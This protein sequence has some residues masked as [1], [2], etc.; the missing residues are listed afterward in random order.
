[1]KVVYVIDSLASK[2]GAE[3]ILSDKMNYLVAQ[4]EFEVYVITCYQ[5]PLQ[6]HN[7]YELSAKVHQMDLSIPY[8]SQYKYRY[9]KRLWIKWRIYCRLIRELTATIQSL[10]P[11]ILVGVSY[12]HA[13]V[14]SCIPCRAF[15]VIESHEVRTFTMSDNGLNRSWLSRLYMRYYKK[16]YFRKVESHADVVV[17]LTNGNAKEWGK[18]RRVEVIPNFTVMPVK[19]LSN[20]LNKRVIAVGRLEWEKGFD[21]LITVWS[22]I[23]ETHPDWR[24]DIFGTGTL[25]S[26]LKV[27]IKQ[28]QLQTVTIHSFTSMIGEEYAQSSI[29]AFS[30]RL[31]GFGLVLLEAMKVGVP[32]V[33]FDCPFGPCDVIENG[34]SG[35]L[36]PDGDIVLFAKKL[37][38]LM[39]DIELRQ[40]FSEAS[41]ERAK[42]FDVDVIMNQW[43][44]LFQ[45]ARNSIDSP[46]K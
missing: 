45:Q 27:Q 4:E 16:C 23:V 13:D 11:E 28:L 25:E 46:S 5:N 2:G 38:L 24:L 42:L 39:S 26:E 36:I 1:M 43:R 21:R 41:I 34:I 33:A 3:R 37:S 32:C 15:K 31:E 9:P 14:V 7:A 8:Y 35:F 18:A 10:D 6:Q 30:S 17:T 20:V 29:L 22:R 19:E 12:F 44:E 40:Q